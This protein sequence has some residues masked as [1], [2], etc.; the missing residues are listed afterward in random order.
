MFQDHV[1]HYSNIRWTHLG[2]LQ[3]G[4]RQKSVDT[5]NDK[6]NETKCARKKE[7]TFTVVH[8]NQHKLVSD[9]HFCT[10]SQSSIFAVMP[11]SDSDMSFPHSHNV[12]LDIM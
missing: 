6:A 3:Y 5:C 1:T 4:P 9:T 8:S 10:V 12:N 2:T 7:V 11:A